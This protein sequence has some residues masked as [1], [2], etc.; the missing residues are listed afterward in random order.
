M[1]L[2]SRTLLLLCSVSADAIPDDEAASTLHVHLPVRLSAHD[3]GKDSSQQRAHIPRA[4]PDLDSVSSLAVA[5][6]I[7]PENDC[8][9]CWYH[10]DATALPSYNARFQWSLTYASEKGRTDLLWTF[11]AWCRV[12]KVIVPTAKDPAHFA[13]G[14]YPSHGHDSRLRFTHRMPL[15][16]LL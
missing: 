3:L 11:D 15:Q 1:M 12:K 16:V 14:R 13:L 5:A 7:K 6:W 10:P 2:R 9:A 8:R 4:N